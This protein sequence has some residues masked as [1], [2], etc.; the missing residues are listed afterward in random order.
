MD[1]L[2]DIQTNLN[3][4][5]VLVSAALVFIMQAG[6]MC[7]EAGMA[8]AKNSINVAIKNLADFVLAVILFWMVG[9]GLMFGETIDGYIGSSNFFIT[10][11]DPWMVVFFVFQ[12][13][14]VGTA[15]TIDSGAVAGRT[16]FWTYLVMSCLISVV[17]YPVFGHWAWGGLLHDQAGW[18]ELR[19]FKDFAGSTVV[20][21]VGGWMAL[22]G[23]IV[24][25][26]RIGKFDKDGKPKKIP[27]HSMTMAYMGTFILFFGWFGFNCGSTLEAS[28]DVASIALNT[29][30]SG[31]FGCFA[32]STL[33]WILSH[34]RRPE[35]EMIANGALAGL[36]G[37]TAGCAFVDTQGA[38]WIGLGAGIL[39]YFATHLIE[40]I[41]KLDDVVGAVAV[42]GVCGAWGTLALG[43]FILPQHLGDMS[44][45]DQI[46]VQALGV[47][48][49]FAWT[50]GVG[51]ILVKIVDI[52][53]GGLRVSR[54]HELI[55]LNIAEHGARMSHIET[56]ETIHYI[57]KTGDLSRR[58]EVE[59]GTEM[60][61]V[62]HTFNML[63]DELEEVVQ[64][65]E[66]VAHGDLSRSVSPKSDH[67]KLGHAVNNMVSGLRSF[68][69]K[70][71]AVS[72]AINGS[73]EELETASHHLSTSNSDLTQ[74]IATIGD[75]VTSG[76]EI[77]Q[78]MQ[79]HAEAGGEDVRTTTSELR[80]MD[81]FLRNLSQEITELGSSSERIGE[82]INAIQNIA[83]QTNLLS[84]NAAIEAVHA[85]EHGKG[86]NVVAREVKTLAESSRSAS[87]EIATLMQLISTQMEDVRVGAVK[88][89]ASSRELL[90]QTSEDLTRSFSEILS[91][92]GKV[93][94]IM[95]VIATTMELQ[96]R[97][98]EHA[99]SAANRITDIKE[100]MVHGSRQLLDVLAFF[101]N[102]QTS[103]PEDQF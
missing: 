64:V 22:V 11:D 99:S 83:Q 66:N 95:N 63:L 102:R 74:H 77:T 46:E 43:F 87:Q 2:A 26:P 101:Q 86:F 3:Y 28:P 20:H 16:K 100:T 78:A 49:C 93:V 56:I 36:V 15:A 33:S 17:I 69:A 4:I 91:S 59:I 61:D 42:H 48:A 98:S 38:M 44:R 8:S 62:A 51:F 27:P 9:F 1:S 24:L 52:F 92:V 47:F 6:F 53:G 21:S 50:F 25:G 96:N 68:V 31:C 76:I 94:D 80:E 60:G 32:S 23:I 14:F 82:F 40:R 85:G 35:G 54:E 57:T 58:V 97:S 67:D 73:V 18:L 30:L 5:W 34:N 75:N 45:M 10:V 12:S 84:L 13:V 79:A 29:I 41:L 89:E 65:T 88:S 55:G 103:S 90:A 37:I 19:G 71:E 81:S 70:V 72:N 39:V 7:L